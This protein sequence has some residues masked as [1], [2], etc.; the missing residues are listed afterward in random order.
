MAFE[1]SRNSTLNMV[2]ARRL[3]REKLL[4][5]KITPESKGAYQVIGILKNKPKFSIEATYDR[6]INQD[7]NFA[8]INAIGGAVGGIQLGLTEGWTK[9]IYKGGSYLSVGLEGRIVYDGETVIDVISD[10]EKLVR[11][12]SPLKFFSVEETEADVI[13]QEKKNKIAEQEKTK[14]I[15]AA[16]KVVGLGK[17]LKDGFLNNVPPE[18]TLTISNYFV[19]AG[20]NVTSVSFEFS[21]EQNKFG[22]LYSDISVELTQSQIKV[23]DVINQSLKYRGING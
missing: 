19:M 5:F 3:A 7:E 8:L 14:G 2:D 16:S 10:T 12:C 21:H 4:V 15:S 18:C 13:E 20:F 22:P 23:G 17:G 6:L 11:L 1:I 9:K